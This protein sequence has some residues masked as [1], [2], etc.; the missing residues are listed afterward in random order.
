MK[1]ATQQIGIPHRYGEGW[2]VPSQ[3]TPGVQYHVNGD[4]TQCECKGF[5]YRRVCAH[6]R[7]VMEAKALI[8]EMLG[9]A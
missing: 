9:D 8:E 2:L 5:A 4:A 6:L 7:M 1:T 3:T